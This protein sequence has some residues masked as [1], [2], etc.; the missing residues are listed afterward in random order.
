MCSIESRTCVPALSKCHANKA[1]FSCPLEKWWSRAIGVAFCSV[2]VVELCGLCCGVT[3][4]VSLLLLSL[5]LCAHQIAGD[6]G[7]QVSVCRLGALPSFLD[8]SPRKI[9]RQQILE[10]L[11]R[12]GSPRHSARKHLRAVNSIFV[13]VSPLNCS[14]TSS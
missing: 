1:L 13:L 4:S 12:D 3:I 6:S 11:R 5:C 7:P 10:R 8:C 14:R 9:A 2:V